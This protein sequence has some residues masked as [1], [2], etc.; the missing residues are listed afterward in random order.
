MR[1]L[2]I[3][4]SIRNIGWAIL[5]T[6]ANTDNGEGLLGSGTIRT[7]Q[8]GDP[9]LVFEIRTLLKDLIKRNNQD[10][11]E[12]APLVDVDPADAPY[13]KLNAEVLA[14]LRIRYAIIEKAEGFTYSRSTKQGGGPNYG[15]ALN[16]KDMQR[17]HFAVGIIAA[18]L[19]EVVEDIQFV[20]PK[21]WKGRQPKATTRLIVNN[22]FN[23][24]LLDYHNDE[25]D[26]IAIGCWWI[27]RWNLEQK[28][29]G[30]ENV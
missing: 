2:A 6:D 15:K 16:A 21:E 17:N 18:T 24:K 10:F 22:T 11:P 4:S 3:D 12:V 23:L 26:A 13:S 9:E 14:G 19:A 20:T 25:V 28:I 8:V 5:E 27:R 29:R 1:I 7:K 30:Q